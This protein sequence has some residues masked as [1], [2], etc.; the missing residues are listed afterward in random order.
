M[1]PHTPDPVTQES[2]DDGL[3]RNGRVKYGVLKKLLRLVWVCV[4]VSEAVESRRSR[5]LRMQC[6]MR[7]MTWYGT[8]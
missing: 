7:S 4:G 3:L 8:S 1:E 5:M 2:S 6:G